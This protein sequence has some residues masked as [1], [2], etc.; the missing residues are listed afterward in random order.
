MRVVNNKEIGTT[1]SKSAANA[2]SEVLTIKIRTPARRRLAIGLKFDLRENVMITLVSYQISHPATEVH[3]KIC[4][5]GR[6]D[7][8]FMRVFAQKPRRSEVRDHLGL[9]M[10]RG[11]VDD[12]PPFLP[13]LDVFKDTSQFV[14][15]RAY[16]VPR[17]DVLDEVQEVDLA[18]IAQDLLAKGRYF[19][20]MGGFF[21]IRQRKTDL[22][23]VHDVFHRHVGDVLDRH[24]AAP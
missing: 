20:E 9:A 3:R 2:N 8:L 17:I 24:E 23:Q 14:M 13:C 15:V 19:L 18:R 1:A 12:D 7:D 6:H 21:V 10:T 4:S 5:V 11:D 16:F 22:H